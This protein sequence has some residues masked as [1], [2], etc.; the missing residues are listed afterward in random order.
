[1]FSVYI[2]TRYTCLLIVQ[3]ELPVQ[4]ALSF[5]GRRD[6]S[7]SREG[8]LASKIVDSAVMSAF[9]SITAPRTSQFFYI[10]IES[11]SHVYLFVQPRTDYSLEVNLIEYAMA[12]VVPWN[13]YYWP[14]TSGGMVA[15]GGPLEKWDEQYGLSGTPQSTRIWELLYHNGTEQWEGHCGRAAA[16]SILFEQPV[17]T[18]PFSED[19]L[20]ALVTELM[21]N[22]ELSM[23]REGSTEYRLVDETTPKPSEQ[24]GDGVP[25]A[26]VGALYALLQSHI[27]GLRRPVIVDLR[28]PNGQDNVARW[29]QAV[30]R[31]ASRYAPLGSAAGGE[32]LQYVE[33]VWNAN[34]DFPPGTHIGNP[35][36]LLGFSRRE[37]SRSCLLFGPDGDVLVD[38]TQNNWLSIVN[39]RKPEE[40]MFIPREVIA[41]PSP[42]FQLATHGGQITEQ[43]LSEWGVRRR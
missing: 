12:R 10:P 9:D 43:R 30:Y 39:D 41:A 17:A 27:S 11:T 42:N 6:A 23:A 40:T 38:A 33:S 22:Y 2:P 36:T 4:C 14:F 3:C 35:E 1:M 37:R 25:D 20:E 24:E 16:A 21:Y 5:S 34:G 28:D 13:F 19:D 32:Q 15:A 8:I 26:N 18:G 31:Y 7:E 29:Y